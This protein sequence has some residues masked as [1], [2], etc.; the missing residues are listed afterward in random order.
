MSHISDFGLDN[1]S[2]VEIHPITPPHYHQ[3]SVMVG[4]LLSEIMETIQERVFNYDQ[5]ETENRAKAL[6]E[7]GKYWVFLAEEKESAS[8]IGFVSVYE[9]YA[10][11]SEGSYGTIPE[12]Y[13]RP[14]W[15]S[16]NIGKRLLTKATDF[17]KIKEWRRLEVTTP[18]LPQFE[19]TLTFY[20]ANGFEVSGGR[21]LKIPLCL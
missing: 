8:I 5:R 16:Q 12:L 9:S 19:R 20:Q 17:G 3:L 6:V 14:K 10:L 7:Q 11:Y 1:M 15:R 13:V 18:P 2:R 21:K 4:E